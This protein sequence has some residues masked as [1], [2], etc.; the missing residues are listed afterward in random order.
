M[1]G[2][3]GHGHPS[4]LR[5]P[6]NRVRFT[7]VFNQPTGLRDPSGMVVDPISWT[8]AAIVCGGGATVGVSYMVFS[9]RKPTIENLAAGA[10]VGCGAGMIGLVSWIAAAGAGA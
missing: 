8:A 1:S 10:A 5:V 4:Q 3:L 7:Y 9:G 2:L 6:R